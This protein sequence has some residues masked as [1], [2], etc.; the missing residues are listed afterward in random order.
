MSEITHE[1]DEFIVYA[2]EQTYTTAG[3]PSGF[4]IRVEHKHLNEGKYLSARYWEDLQDKVNLQI[5]KWETKWEKQK[6]IHS[7]NE[8]SNIA[9]EETEAARDEI[10]KLENIL[11]HTLDIDDTLDWNRLKV[12]TDYQ[13]PKPEKP[14]KTKQKVEKP[15]KPKRSDIIKPCPFYKSFF[16]GRVKWDAEQEKNFLSE[17]ERWEK[18]V[19]KIDDDHDK[20]ILD[21]EKKLKIFRTKQLEWETSRENFESKQMKKNQAV[22]NLKQSYFDQDTDSITKYCHLV[23]EA[24]EYPDYFP[25]NFN[26]QYTENTNSLVVDY[27]LPNQSQIPDK[28][29]VNY[30]KTRDEYSEKHMPKN[31]HDKL[32]ESVGYQIALRTIHELFES[33]SADVISSV[34]FNGLICDI[35]KSTG[36]EVTATILSV[37]VLKENF[38]KINL[39]DVEPKACFKSL[40]GV[41][42]PKLS[43]ITPIA[44]LAQISEFDG[45]FTDGYGVVDNIDN[46][47]NLASMHWEDFEHLIREIFEKE[48]S[49]DG[50]EV[51]ITQASSDGGVDAIAFDPDPIK[52]GKIVI[53]AKRYTN[54]VGVSAVRDLFG[55]VMNEGANKGILVTTSDYGPDSYD[56]AK[57]KPITLLNG[58]NLLNLLEKYG[59]NAKIDILQAKQDLEK[60]KT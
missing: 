38:L 58:A 39:K 30:I 34:T 8:K 44:P 12:C 55:T 54:T 40:K 46:A 28:V 17:L 11:D 7:K 18:K 41:A 5:S 42:A 4:R 45:R 1:T 57:D 15:S 3:N 2:A 53:Q 31:Q 48:F 36:Q 21:Y 50:G 51:K 25:Q 24:S 14:K 19:K 13:V 20:L 37:Y 43:G 22:D 35:D 6:K 16:G 27:V 49:K 33:D 23:L 10:K 9:K 26:L 52:G 59:H 29:Q 56:F 60:S 47:T 32:F